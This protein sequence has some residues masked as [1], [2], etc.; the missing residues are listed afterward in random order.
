MSSTDVAV[1]VFANDDPLPMAFASLAH[2]AGYMEAI[3]VEDGLYSSVGEGGIRGGVFAVDG[4][5]VDVQSVDG[6]VVLAVTD[7]RDDGGLRERLA[8]VAADGLI[9]SALDDPLGAA[10][11]LLEQQWASRWPQRPRWLDRRL[12]GDGPPSVDAP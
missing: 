8:S 10:R 3:D 1:I 12:H 5:V 7:R 6:G 2:A 11:E 4:R 9:D